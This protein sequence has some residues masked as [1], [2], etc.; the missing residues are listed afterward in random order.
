MPNRSQPAVALARL[1]LTIIS[2]RAALTALSPLLD[3]IVKTFDLSGGEAGLLGT[4]PL[5]CFALL[6]FA[7]VAVVARIGLEAALGWTMLTLALGALT[8]ALGSSAALFA[9][10]LLGGAGA[11]AATAL[12]PAVVR[13]EWGH[14]GAAMAIYA[15]L[16]TWGGGFASALSQP[17][18]LLTPLGWQF[19]LGFW[20][21]P[22]II[23]AWLWRRAP[24]A[25]AHSHPLPAIPIRRLLR[26]S[27][28]WQL[29]MFCGL[30]TLTF[31]IVIA[32][33]P[34]YLQGAGFAPQSSGMLLGLM[35][36][37]AVPP[38]ILIAARAR[39]ARQQRALAFLASMAMA[40]GFCGYALA[41]GL[42]SLWI[43]FTGVGGGACVSLGLQLIALRSAGAPTLIALS[44]MTQTVSYGVAALGP[45]LFGLGRDLI[46][47]WA[48]PFFCVAAIAVL[49]ALFGLSAG[50]DRTIESELGASLSSNPVAAG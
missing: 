14:F 17:L 35:Q 41:P 36:I 38:G 27:L 7:G 4:L 49:Q 50:R 22:A 9:G 6:S 5:L 11:A 45:V 19:S 18:A 44:A 12:V 48:P 16:T 43:F 29:S 25:E 30:N 8:R 23:A 39:T 31:F 1:L 13:R 40:V 20:A 28:A 32:W 2:M 26:S 15:L 10:T 47:S 21:L 33:L 37:L 34:A 3:P 46:G 24:T 42:S